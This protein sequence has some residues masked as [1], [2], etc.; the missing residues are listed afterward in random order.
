MDK[1]VYF[2]VE[3]AIRSATS[4]PCKV[5]RCSVIIY[6]KTATKTDLSSHPNHLAKQPIV[7]T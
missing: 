3:N 5:S 4:G 1:H 2:K 6:Y 7:T